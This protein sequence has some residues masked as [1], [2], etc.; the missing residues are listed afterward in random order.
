MNSTTQID[1]CVVAHFTFRSVCLRPHSRRHILYKVTNPE[2]VSISA[3]KVP[4]FIKRARESARHDKTRNS[5]VRA[6]THANK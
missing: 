3:T 6:T 1:R 2:L 5:H 4:L